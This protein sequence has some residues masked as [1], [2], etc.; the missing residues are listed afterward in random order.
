MFHVIRMGRR[1]L[2]TLTLLLALML[3]CS[4]LQAAAD[5]A[6]PEDLIAFLNQTILW[7]RQLMSQQQL[8]IEPSD[9][10]FLN[11]SHEI[12]DQVVHLSFEFARTDAPLIAAQAKTAQSGVDPSPAV[13][14]YQNLADLAAKA[15]QRV[16]ETQTE[17]E[18]L[19][20]QLA[21]AT[22]PQRRILVSSIAEV[23]SELDLNTVRRDSMQSMLEFSRGANNNASGA[24]GLLAQIEELARITHSGASEEHTD[25]AGK[26]GNDG[27]KTSNN[28]SRQGRDLHDSHAIETTPVAIATASDRKAGSGGILT[29]ASDLFEL[30]RKLRLLDTSLE[31]TDALGR[32][33]LGFRQPFMANIREMARRGDDLANEPDSHDPVV[34][35]QQRKELD[36][37][38]AKFKQ[39]AALS[40]PLGKQSILLDQY[41]R[42]LTNWRN[43]VQGQYSARAKGLL[44]RLLF[45]V[46]ALGAIFLSAELWRK[47]TFRYVLDPRRRHQFL[48]MRRIIVWPLT[49]IIIVI[50]IA[51]GLGSITTFAGLLTAGIAVSLQNVILSAAGYFFLIG[52]YGVRVGDRIQISGTTG[53]VIDIGLFRMHLMEVSSSPGAKPTGRVVAFS[54]GIVFQPDAAIFK[55]IPGTSFVWHEVSLTLEP[56]TDY[57]AIEKHMLET[58]NAIFADYREK[59][60]LQHSSMKSAISGQP[61]GNLTPE[62]R[63]QIVSEGIQVMVRYPVEMENAAAIDDRVTREVLQATGHQPQVK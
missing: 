19:K 42:N 34:L 6:R 28:K 21:T 2:L 44:W 46:G 20:L 56:R 63:L 35:A 58:V 51:N 37:L 33:A 26:D 11:D 23:Q 16:K 15:A 9:A 25:T 54:N 60:D 24:S 48:I 10:I 27:G 41:K 5:P 18:G 38:T 45:L 52:K 62:S 4:G 55:Q 31:M 61:A 7:H 12:S 1:L 3:V 57:Q 53:D 43:V 50:S 40:L 47:A 49:I 8:V 17:L 22:G 29:L 13:S 14:Q 39:V 36:G 59:M 32:T 30:R